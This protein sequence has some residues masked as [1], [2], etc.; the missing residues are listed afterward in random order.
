M[1]HERGEGRDDR[2]AHAPGALLGRLALAGRQRV[3]AVGE[4]SEPGAAARQAV[5]P[6]FAALVRHPSTALK[7]RAIR[8]LEG[9]PEDL[10]STALI[11]SLRDGD[12][13]VVRAALTAVVATPNAHAAAPVARLLSTSPS[14]SLRAVSA[15]ALG[16]LAAREGDAGAEPAWK[17][18][19]QAATGDSFAVVREAALGAL[20]RAPPGLRAEALRKAASDPEPSVQQ[21]AARL[22]TTRP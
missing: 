3:E 19:A 21:L 8:V 18:L 6:A 15:S 17:A 12:E 20:D 14:W 13:A 2:L 10:A 11:E 4:G 1:A 7:T 22:S 9:R 5:V 16:A